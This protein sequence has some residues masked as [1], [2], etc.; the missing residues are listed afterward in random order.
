MK[1]TFSYKAWQ[2]ES[3]AK[4][5][6][7]NQRQFNM[8]RSIFSFGWNLVEY[9]LDIFQLQTT[10]FLYCTFISFLGASLTHFAYFMAI[11][12]RILLTS[13]WIFVQCC[14][15]SPKSKMAAI[16]VR[17]F[18]SSRIQLFSSFL[19]F[20][21]PLLGFNF[22]SGCDRDLPGPSCRAVNLTKT[23]Q[24]PIKLILI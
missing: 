24:S 17:C 5:L 19:T 18:I 3:F 11:V 15:R 9:S 22:N 10:E 21:G 20:P 8:P 7:I 2:S 13:W 16:K 6:S 4:I 14:R 23:V 1:K 12:R